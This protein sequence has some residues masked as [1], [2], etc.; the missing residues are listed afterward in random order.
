[1]SFKFNIPSLEDLDADDSE[2]PAVVFVPKR[3]KLSETR[4]SFAFPIHSLALNFPV[5][6]SAANHFRDL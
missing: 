2:A 5:E 3:P 6:I 4:A 1:M